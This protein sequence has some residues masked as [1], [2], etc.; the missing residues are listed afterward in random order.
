MKYAGWCIAMLCSM[1]AIAQ[2]NVAERCAAIKRQ[3]ANAMKVTIADAAEDAYDV[4][5][6]KFDIQ[7]TNLSSAISGHV[8]TTA[9]VVA[10]AMPVYVFEL[11]T[12]LVAD[13]VFINDIPAIVTRNG[14]V[15]TATMPAPL[16]AG[17]RFT[18][19]VHYHGQPIPGNG[20]YRTGIN[21]TVADPW[22]VMV[23]YTLSEPYMANR[24]WPCKQSLTDKIDSADIWIAIPGG[25]KAGSNGLL[26]NVTALG[27]GYQRYEWHTRYPIAYYLLSAAVAPYADYSFNV[28]MPGSS[29][30]LPVQN[31]IYDVP[32][33]LQTYK[34]GIDSTAQ[35]LQYFAEIFGPYPFDKEKYGHC[36]VPLPGGME[37]QTMT[38]QGDFGPLLTAH[39]LAHQ[40]FGNH[41]TC[42]SWRDIWLN[43]GFATYGEYLFLQRWRPG[44]AVAHMRTI[45]NR[46]ISAEAKGGAVYVDDTTNDDRIFD[47]RLSYNKAGAVIH[48][49]R[50]LMDDDEKFFAILKAYQNRYAFG[51]ATTANFKALAEEITGRD[52]TTFFNQ[53][54]YGEGYPVYS[55]TWN[56]I[57]ADVFLKLQQETAVPQSVAAY[58]MPVPIR[59]MGPQGDTTIILHNTSHEQMVKLSWNKM[60][61]QVQ[62]D[63]DNWILNGENINRRDPQLGLNELTSNNIIVFPNP[64]QDYW[65]V[66]GLPEGCEMRLTDLAGRLVQRYTNGA[67]KSSVID[68]NYLHKGMYIL[69]IMQNEKKIATVKLIKI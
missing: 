19:R 23:T 66:A 18:A 49:L 65:Y 25:L 26:K 14:L 37:H 35:M 53:W 54:I 43:E 59:L 10:D 28:A 61:T 8:I 67:T 33:A 42:G 24:W 4:K 47:G 64:S 2:E 6:V 58:D 15:H 12:P 32:N 7:L 1:A 57:K 30:P 31:F 3:S 20:Y 36:L 60:I 27:N 17:Q 48:M 63:P 39:E 69:T 38:T 40:W 62:I 34:A 22:G 5:H 68:A 44:D 50:Y 51:N 9:T 41:V 46:V 45:H 55:I 21:N 13:S 29:M 56:K 52:F 11:D 16:N